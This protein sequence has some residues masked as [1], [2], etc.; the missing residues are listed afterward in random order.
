[1]K[2]TFKTLF[3]AA[4]FTGIGSTAFAQLGTAETI[5]INAKVL[6]QMVLAGTEVRFGAVTAGNVAILDPIDPADNRFVSVQAF[7]GRILVDATGGERIRV[8]YPAAVELTHTNGTDAINY[9]PRVSVIW[10][11]VGI[12]DLANRANSILL[13]SDDAF[14]A[15]TNVTGGAGSGIGGL[16]F[17]STKPAAPEIDLTTMFIGGN[18]YQQN[19]TSVAIPGGQTTGSYSGTI[20]FDLTYFDI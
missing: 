11:N 12:A 18:L 14:A 6:K 13:D 8:T 4:L 16:G 7:P 20:T 5:N 10:G 15:G 9:V 1:M 2:T 17:F 3:A 19:S